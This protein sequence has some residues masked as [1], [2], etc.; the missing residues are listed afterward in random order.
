MD[1]YDYGFHFT[2]K[3]F[4]CNITK[5]RIIIL[6]SRTKYSILI[7]EKAKKK[8]HV[9][10]NFSHRFACVWLLFRKMHDIVVSIAFVR[11]AN[12]NKHPRNILWKMGSSCVWAC[13]KFHMESDAVNTTEL[14]F[15]SVN[16]CN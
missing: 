11:K 3:L 7:P 4:T 10:R 6:N 15:V 1:W 9:D 16:Y 14:P 2:L 5:Y 12:V 13:N 8:K